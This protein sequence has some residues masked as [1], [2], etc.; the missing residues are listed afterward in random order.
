MRKN[1][2]LGIFEFEDYAME[3]T[4]K[5]LILVNG[6]YCSGGYRGSSCG[7]GYS[8]GYT[9]SYKGKSSPTYSS[10]GG[11]YTSTSYARS[12]SSSSYGNCGGYFSSTSYGSCSG[13][14]TFNI[15]NRINSSIKQN[16]DKK[17]NK[18]NDGYK[19]D[20]WVQ[21]VLTD[22]KFDYNDYFAGDANRKTCEEHIK[23][24][25]AG[26]YTTDMPSKN[27]VYIVLMNNGHKYTKEDGSTGTYAAHTGIL[28]IGN[29]NPCFYDN[30]SG[31]KTGGVDK[32]IGNS[33]VS[34][35]MNQFGYDSFY[36]MK[37]E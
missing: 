8:G 13:G 25:K 28:V 15:I 12:N 31:N 35:V 17:Y 9:G 30:S 6:G 19:C 16:Y 18:D 26:T 33:T 29:G 21:E 2:D 24:L 36:Y 20:N 37:V 14:K 32:T 11:S 7:G 27:G 1:Y 23:S 5:E 10:C 22:A 4:S 3:I 34:S